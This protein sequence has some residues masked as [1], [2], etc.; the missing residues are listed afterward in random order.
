MS[1]ST[2]TW[3]RIQ[4]KKSVS[5]AALKL[6]EMV[7]HHIVMRTDKQIGGNILSLHKTEGSAKI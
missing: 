4:V 5:W 3:A 7:C 2:A 6:N 1:A